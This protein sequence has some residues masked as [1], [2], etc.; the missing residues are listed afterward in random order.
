MAGN[1]FFFA[2]S[3]EA[4]SITTERQPPATVFACA[5]ACDCGLSIGDGGAIRSSPSVDGDATV[6]V[7]GGLIVIVNLKTLCVWL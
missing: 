2:R 5:G 4:P 3:P 6:P 1:V 7:V